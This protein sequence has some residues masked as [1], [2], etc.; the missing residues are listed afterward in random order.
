MHIARLESMSPSGFLRL[1]RQTDGDIVIS[2]CQGDDKGNITQTATVEFC[3]FAGGGGSP[4]TF[5]ALYQ[6]MRAMAEDTLD[7]E[8]QPRRH[9]KCTDDD[10]R[11]IVEYIKAVDQAE[12]DI[13]VPKVITE[14]MTLLKAAKHLL[15]AATGPKDSPEDWCETRGRLLEKINEYDAKAN[16]AKP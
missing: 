4:K 6:L 14:M 8:S 15:M 1:I 9:R 3:T 2:V 10:A 16:P 5:R 13:A 7:P 12:V 11:L